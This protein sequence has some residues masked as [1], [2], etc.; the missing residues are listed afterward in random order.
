MSNHVH[1]ILE[2]AVRPGQL[3]A[4]KALMPEMVAATQANEPG[5]LNY[6]WY[7]SDDETQCHIYERYEDSAAVMAHLASFGQHFA[8]RFL[9]AVEPTGFVVY[10]D[11]D[12]Q[13]RAALSE[14]AAVHMAPFGGFVR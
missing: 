2:L 8:V 13:V 7:L 11:P 12:A 3:D 10:G 6:E 9:D 1:W 4:L 14:F 5:T